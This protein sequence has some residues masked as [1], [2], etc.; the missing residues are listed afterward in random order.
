[1][2]VRAVALLALFATVASA[3]ALPKAAP[4]PPTY[5]PGVDVLDYDIAIELP[6]TGA[7]LRGD[8]ALTLRKTATV[9]RLKLDLVDSLTVRNVEVNG[10]AVT[11]THTGGK[12]DIP[13]DGAGDSMR[14]RVVYDGFVTDG[15]VVRKDAK[16][17]WTWFG[18]NWP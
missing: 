5:Q 4:A 11:T 2:I 3:Q 18:D 16:G 15:L 12:I 10:H 8:L 7:F 6:D 9:T 13:L 17:R 14:V 1:M